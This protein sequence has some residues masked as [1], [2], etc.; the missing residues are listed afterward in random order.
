MSVKLLAVP[1]SHPCAAVAAMLDAKGVHYD[2]VDLVPGLSRAWLRVTGFAGATVP[3]LR[4]NR[5]RVQGSRAIARALDTAWPDPP[6]FPTDPDARHHTEQ[7]EAWADGP[8]QQT[9]RRIALWSLL[10]SPAAVRAA[11][12]GARLQ[13]HL[14]NRLAAL[15]VI[16]AP[17]LALDAAING[18]RSQAV[19][20]DLRTLPTTLDRID[21]WIAHGAL[22]DAPPTAADYQIAASIRLL[23]TIADLQPVLADRPAARLA[24]R[25]IPTFPGDVPAGVLPPTWLPAKAPAR[26]A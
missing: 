8:F 13:F 15:P 11:L 17:V 24:R 7:I 2:R 26:P 25:L 18:A 16:A 20:T 9:A 22:G 6:L 1:A 21:E 5:T 4:I 23:L 10:H 14:P 19:R 12:H 3:A